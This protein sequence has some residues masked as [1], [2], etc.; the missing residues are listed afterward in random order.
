MSVFQT[1]PPTLYAQI[2]TSLTAIHWHTHGAWP[3]PLR[4]VRTKWMASYRAIIKQILHKTA[5]T[6]KSSL[7]LASRIATKPNT[8]SIATPFVSASNSF[9]SSNWNIL[10]SSIFYTIQRLDKYMYSLPELSVVFAGMYFIQ[11]IR[12]TCKMFENSWNSK[13]QRSA[14][15]SV[16]DWIW[17]FFYDRDIFNFPLGD[18]VQSKSS[19]RHASAAHFNFAIARRIF[20]YFN[21]TFVLFCIN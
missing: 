5:I 21:L 7:T 10:L 8:L 16:C 6:N 9:S 20:L 11:F 12:V 17:C 2:M 15:T 13:R 14:S 18:I 1:H 4:C 3:P 19:M